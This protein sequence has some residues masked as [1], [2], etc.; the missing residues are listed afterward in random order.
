MKKD[1][2]STFFPISGLCKI[3]SM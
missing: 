2:V 1:F 3:S